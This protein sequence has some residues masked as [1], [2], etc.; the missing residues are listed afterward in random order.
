M[1][2][3]K[4]HYTSLSEATN[5]LRARGYKYDFNLKPECIEC[6][7]LQ[8]QLSPEKFTIDEFHHFEGMSSTDDNSIVFAITA[9]NGLKGVLVDA[10][11]VYAS[12]LND[13]MI[14]KLS[15]RR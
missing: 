14:K 15:I 4:K 5:D 13:S 11:G 9:E 1:N 8:L 6:P 12:S 10:Y 3:T 2:R 7:A